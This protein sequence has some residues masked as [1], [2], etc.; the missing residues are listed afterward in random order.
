MVVA[1]ERACL[2]LA[3]V[4]SPIQ[5]AEACAI[6]T[7]PT[8]VAILRASAAGTIESSES[9][10]TL[11]GPVDAH[12]LAR[13]V[14]GTGIEAAVRPNISWLAE[15]HA[16]LAD[17]PIRAILGTQGGEAVFARPTLVTEARAVGTFS[18]AV[19]V[20]WAPLDTAVHTSVSD[21]TLALAIHTVTRTRAIVGA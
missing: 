10:I 14:V 6:N 11:A 21:V 18:I 9:R 16:F 19:A 4:T 7:V 2:D 3:R 12:T 15:A 8:I 5:S 17:T 20:V 1:V 13:A